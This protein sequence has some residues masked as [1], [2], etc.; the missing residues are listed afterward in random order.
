[1]D[2][3]D[4]RAHLG[5]GLSITT[6]DCGGIRLRGTGTTEDGTTLRTALLA[7][8]TPAA[9]ATPV[10]T[11]DTETC[12]EQPD[13]RDHGARLW[14]ALLT[15]AQHALDTDAVPHSHGTKPRVS[16]TVSHADLHEETGGVG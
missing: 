8:A 16:V 7:L 15:L 4:R 5:R 10:P 1:M 12:Q 11:I 14:D 9:P 3:E 13:P 2:R 6:D